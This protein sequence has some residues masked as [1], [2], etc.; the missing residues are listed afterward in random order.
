MKIDIHVHTKKTKQGD[1]TTREIDAKRFHEIISSTEVKIVAITNHNVF[2]SAQYKEFVEAVADDFQIWPGV[3]LDVLEDG[4]KGHLI[5]VVSPEHANELE[6]TIVKISKDKSPD[7]FNISI[8]KVISNFDKLNPLY[9]AHYQQKKP[10]LSDE[11]IE[12]IIASTSN[13]NRV[14]K[15]ATNAVS[16]GIFISHGHASI[17][18]SDLQVW[19]KYQSNSKNLPDLR[20]PVESF[21]QFCLL[22]DKD[23]KAIDTLL[24]K[25]S[26]E[27]I[28]IK[29]FNDDSRLELVVYDDINIFFGA[30]GT[31]KSDILT[32]IGNY[33]SHKGI[34]CR[35]FEAG[36]GTLEEL[37]DFGGKNLQLDLNDYEIKY[38]QKEIEF[39][40]KA[41]EVSITSL[42]KY[43]NFY[44]GKSANKKA[45]NIKIKD[46][47]KVDTKHFERQFEKA[48]TS[49]SK[50]KEF[51]KFIE[52]DTVIKE[53][54]TE[55]KF[56]TL[57]SIL[58]EAIQGL[59]EKNFE[60]FS[61]GKTAYL[62]NKIIEIFKK[63]ISKKTGAPAKPS[64]TG[65]R[66][67]AE[68]RINIER[69]AKT[70]SVNINKK[71]K[72][73]EVYV[74]NLDD[75]G[76][77]YCKTEIAIQNGKIIDS[78][79]KTITKSAKKKAQKEFS[80]KIAS[81]MDKV[82]TH[83]LFIE[84]LELNKI[85]DIDTIPTIVELLIFNKTFTINSSEYKPS[86]GEASMILLHKE[87][88]EDKDVYI[89]DEPEKSL[90]NEYINNVIVPLIKEK[91]KI[92]KKLFIATHDANIAVRTLPYNS[93]YREHSQEGYK[94]YVGN[95]FSNNLVEIKRSQKK[96]DW[97]NISMRTL[98]GGKEA[99]G[100]RGQIYGNP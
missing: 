66:K 1:A 23:Q 5:V 45:N 54:L 89:L 20:L 22:L 72:P 28:L 94:T 25:K 78:K 81:I 44:K 58:T 57:I 71:I 40:K 76:E 33:Y 99:F 38:C 87:L 85:D 69:A 13:K 77:L 88:S 56:D 12:Q 39:V 37:Y 34:G 68:N 4:R 90:G 75:K 65:F 49:D 10:H 31:G 3:E 61:N 96:L 46:F 91:A 100:E 62:F 11:D 95:P 32:A 55:E 82:Y 63:E 19:E 24:D 60:E 70:I 51:K 15:E 41:Q 36:S 93:V 79:F 21:E 47:S 97:K 52:K 67:Y 27:K 18:G 48:Q 74:G 92:G 98:E 50:V 2:D 16:A 84:I 83:D 7:D 29:P 59:E 8:S 43:M 86:T 17:Y 53:I 6:E 42:S 14:L 9:I 73:T 64:E 35:K 26:R 30:K 80:K